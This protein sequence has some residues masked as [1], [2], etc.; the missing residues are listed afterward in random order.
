MKVRVVDRWW[1]VD[2]A[3][4]KKTVKKANSGQRVRW[5]VTHDAEQ[6]NGTRKLVSKNFDRVVDAEEYR[7]RTA[8]E[9]RELRYRRREITKKTHADAAAA[10]FSSTKKPT[11]SSLMRYRD[12]LDIW[13]L[14][15][16]S[17]QTLST[18]PHTEI[19]EWV[20]AMLDGTSPYAEG[21][22]VRGTGMAPSGLTAI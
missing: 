18:V 6:P 14:P 15:A 17:R 5:Q 12:A 22:K 2:P 19:D 7:T 10:W 3:T 16:W 8:H 21:R 1:G 20:T 9:L 11:G 13:V 4:G